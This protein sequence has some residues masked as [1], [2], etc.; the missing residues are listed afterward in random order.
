MVASG[1]GSYIFDLGGRKYFDAVASLWCASLGFSDKRLAAAGAAA[2]ETLP[3]YHTF[4]QRSNPYVAELS[5]LVAA[6]APIADAKVF[7]T[8]GAPKPSIRW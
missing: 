7:F 2:L 3:V 4:N 1:Q 5:S 8:D 6:V